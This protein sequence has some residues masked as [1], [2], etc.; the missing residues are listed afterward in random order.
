MP[1]HM[2]TRV[3][4]INLVILAGTS[5][6]AVGL[7]G[8]EMCRTQC[9]PPRWIGGLFARRCVATCPSMACQGVVW[10]LR[11]GRAQSLTIGLVAIFKPDP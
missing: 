3:I 2:A 10:V 4:T 1:L 8:R 9:L 5:P 11:A 6:Y 7:N